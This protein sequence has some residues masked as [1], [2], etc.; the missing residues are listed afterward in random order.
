MRLYFDLD[1]RSFVTSPGTRDILSSLSFKRGDNFEVVVQ[2]IQDAVVQELDGA[3]T[4]K[5]GLKPTDDFD[6][7][8]VAIDEAWT[9]AGTGTDTTYTFQ[10]DLFTTELEALFTTADQVSTS[11]NLEL[12]YIISGVR[13]SSNSVLTTV[14]NDVIKDGD[15]TPTSL[16]SAE[17]WLDLRSPR[18]AST[19]TGLTGGAST[20]L[21]GIE[22]EDLTAGRLQLV[23]VSGNIYIYELLAE[24]YAE[25]SPSVIRPDDYATS[26]NEKVWELKGI[27]CGSIDVESAT[28]AGRGRLSAS[29][30]TATRTVTFPN[31][32][33]VMALEG[34]VST[35]TPTTGFS[36]GLTGAADATL[37]LTPA[38]TLATGTIS[39]PDAANA[40]A[41]QEIIIHST[42]EITASTINVTGGGTINGAAVTTIAA[43]TSYAFHCVST[44]GTGTW[45]R[46]Y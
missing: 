19:I 40:R 21:D 41:Q 11:L 5:L 17:D 13:T 18:W 12:E 44:A 9:K 37:F 29:G 33:G 28:S 25:D 14:F 2:F 6:T 16:P 22:T 31:R 24:T 8:P 20:D 38:G 45:I 3:A 26:T 10:L 46:L 39:L 32:N 27:T 34:A 43:D 42:E 30:L 1:L 35:L 15:A 23:Q 4:G 36:Q 7:D